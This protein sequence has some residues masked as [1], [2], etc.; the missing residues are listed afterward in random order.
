MMRTE[1]ISSLVAVVDISKLASSDLRTSRTS[2]TFSYCPG[3][4]LGKRRK[5]VVMLETE[6]WEEVIKLLMDRSRTMAWH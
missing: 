4:K 2:Q 6:K 5:I 1:N 3:R